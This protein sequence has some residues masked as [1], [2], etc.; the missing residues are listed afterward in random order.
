MVFLEPAKIFQEFGAQRGLVQALVRSDETTAI[1]WDAQQQ[2]QEN[3]M[4]LRIAWEPIADH[5]QRAA[6]TE[7]HRL[8]QF[9]QRSSLFWQA[10]KKTESRATRQGELLGYLE[11]IAEWEQ[12][13]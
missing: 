10:A 6:L 4:Q 5:R 7:I 11:K 12:V 3:F 2:L 8:L 9:V 13:F 1:Y